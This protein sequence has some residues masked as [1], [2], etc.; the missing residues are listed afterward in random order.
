MIYSDNK[1][2]SLLLAAV[3]AWSTPIS[4]AAV[5]PLDRVAVV[6]NDDIIMESQVKARMRDVMQNI[7]RQGVAAPPQDVVLRQVVEQLIMDNIQMQIAQRAGVRID[8]NSLNATM[9]RIAN[10]NN[11]TLE[12]F[13]QALLQDG[14]SYQET[15]E[16]VRREMITTRVREGRVGS[17][18]QITDQEIDNLLD[19]EAGKEQLQAA[20]NLAHLL[21]QVPEDATPEEEQKF[22]V[23]A[24]N[25]YHQIEAGADFAQLARQF[26]QGP[27][28]EEGGNMGWRAESQLPSI[29]A[30]YAPS[31][32]PGE[33]TKPFRSPNG[34]HL[35]KLINKR[36]GDTIMVPQYHVRH[37]LVKPSEIRTEEQAQAFISALRQQILDGE[38]F[39]EL[40]RDNSDDTGSLASGGDLDWMNPGDLVPK[41]REVMLASEQNVLS[42]PFRSQFGWHILEVLGEREQNVGKQVKRRRAREIIYQRK[43][44]E[45][46]QIWLREERDDAYVDIKLY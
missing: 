31:L 15:R 28:A 18:I 7:Q 14:T 46:L 36:G 8:D 12:Q 34:F 39:A 1:L 2:Y 37:I 33:V 44:E 25:L 26:S 43:F 23:Q 19:S 11:M 3:L 27:A 16:Q 35:L 5:T 24:L 29:F 20:Y 13:Q 17:R 45:E 40:A 6:V 41:F 4:Q 21:I 42:E 30:Q 32:E 22:E 38:D 9:A 10:Q